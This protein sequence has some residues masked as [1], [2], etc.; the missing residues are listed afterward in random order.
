MCLS[1]F[2]LEEKLKV[3]GGFPRERWEQGKELPGGDEEDAEPS[4]LQPGG[5]RS[6]ELQDLRRPPGPADG[7]G[8]PVWGRQHPQS[9]AR[10][11]H[12]VWPESLQKKQSQHCTVTETLGVQPGDP[13]TAEVDLLTHRSS[14]WRCSCCNETQPD[15]E[16]CKAAEMF[17]LLCWKLPLQFLWFSCRRDLLLCSPSSQEDVWWEVQGVNGAELWTQVCSLACRGRSEDAEH[18]DA[19]WYG[20]VY[21]VYISVLRQ[22]TTMKEVVWI[23][24]YLFLK[25]KMK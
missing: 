15:W 16:A 10:L 4:Q 14:G 22:A 21:L 18:R 3:W 1:S 8:L 19:R 6:P 5:P 24:S 13:A 9:A 7:H 17:L 20:R 23:G 11:V 2:S 12:W 25:C